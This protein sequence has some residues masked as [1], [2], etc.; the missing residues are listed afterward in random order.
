MCHA[1]AAMGA[2]NLTGFLNESD[3][4]MTWN[5]IF[6]HPPQQKSIENSDLSKML[7]ENCRFKKKVASTHHM[8]SKVGLLDRTGR[9]SFK[10]FSQ[11]YGAL[12]DTQIDEALRRI[13]T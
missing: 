10:D 13:L 7:C 2:Q 12:G 6:L 5:S 8:F 3:I 9:L 1:S 11:E 4:F